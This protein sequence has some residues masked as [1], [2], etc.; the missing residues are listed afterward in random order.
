MHRTVVFSLLSSVAPGG[1][2]LFMFPFLLLF[3]VHTIED[4]ASSL[5]DSLSVIN[6]VLAPQ[7]KHAMLR[8]RALLSVLYA[9]YSFAFTTDIEKY[10]NCDGNFQA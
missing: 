4:D 6:C 1:S 9:V 2:L 7:K 8:H 10:M 3:T 5:L